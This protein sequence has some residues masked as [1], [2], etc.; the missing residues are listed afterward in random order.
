[1]T[2]L[3]INPGILIFLISGKYA[4]D[5]NPKVDLVSAEVWSDKNVCNYGSV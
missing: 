1:L 4:D 2:G 5:K 3:K